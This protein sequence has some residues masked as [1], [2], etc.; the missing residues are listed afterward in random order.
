MTLPFMQKFPKAIPG[1]GGKETY[2]I[3][4]IYTS[5]GD[6]VRSIVVPRCDMKIPYKIRVVEP[7]ELVECIEKDLVYSGKFHPKHHTIRKGNRFKKGDKIHMVINN[8]TKNRFQF[9]PVLEVKSVQKIFMTDYNNL[10]IT[11]S[12]RDPFFYYLYYKDK[13][14]LALNDGFESYKDF[15]AFFLHAMKKEHEFS[16]QIIH[17]TDLRY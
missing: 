4:K 16:G 8:R 2:F 15:E 5:I 17:W 11:I 10:E 14:Q 6:T 9:A 3:E 12:K 1:I 13:E 7:K